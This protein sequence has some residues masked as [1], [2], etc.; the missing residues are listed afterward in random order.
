M[1]HERA[2]VP[3]SRQSSLAS[4]QRR[5]GGAARCRS[6][7]AWMMFAVVGGKDGRALGACELDKNTIAKAYG[8][9]APVYDLVFG[10]V[11]DQGR[12]DAVGA[13]E[14]LGGRDLAGGS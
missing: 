9:W 2:P 10:A 3:R 1:G 13:G 14:G 11:F 8:R 12:R 6:D 7:G 4:Q 5:R